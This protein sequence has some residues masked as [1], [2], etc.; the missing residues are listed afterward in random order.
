MRYVFN[1]HYAFLRKHE[2]ELLLIVANFDEQDVQAAVNI[3]SDAFNYFKL[4]TFD[5]VEATELLTEQSVELSLMPDTPVRLT[6][7]GY[8]GVIVKFVLSTNEE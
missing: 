1:R 8:S 7:P 2:N 3:P 6:L 5:T 4:P